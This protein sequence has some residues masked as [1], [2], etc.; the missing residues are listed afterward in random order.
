MKLL[1]ASQMQDVDSRAIDERGIPGL[2]LMEQAGLRCVDEIDDMFAGHRGRALI[3]VGK[4]NNGGDGLVIARHLRKG[5]WKVAVFCASNPDE[6]SGDAAI[7]LRRIDRSS[8]LLF[9]DMDLLPS[10]INDSDLIVDALLGTGL[11]STLKGRYLDII[12][13]VNDS[14][15]VVLAVDLPSGV[16]ATTGEVMGVAILADV[17]VTFA[18]PKLGHVLYPGA[19]H[20]GRLVVVDIGIPP[21]LL[22][23]EGAVEYIDLEAASRLIRRRSP[24]AHK[25]SCGHCLVVAGST[26]KTGAAAMAANSAVRSGAGLVTAAIPESLNLIMEIKTDEAMTLP[27]PDGCRGAFSPESM[28]EL[29]KALNG[30]SVLALGPGISLTDGVSDVVASLLR[31]IAIPAVVDADGLNAIA[32]DV[33]V[34]QERQASTPLVLTPHPGELSRLCR[35]SVAEIE[36]DR[37]GMARKT[38]F[39]YGV[40]LVL[41]GA[42]TVVASP[43]GAIAINGSGNAGMASG[44]MGD[45]LTGVIAALLAQGYEPES[46]CRL[47]VFAHGLAADIA[48]GEIGEIGLCATEVMKQLPLA[49]NRILQRKESISC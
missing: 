46:A 49:F 14:D 9:T 4:G 11:T 43:D 35:C 29:V 40:W 3:L 18:A 19:T 2:E 44:G 12:T 28:P 10:L 27:I 42:R 8:V 1:T 6:F 5:G 30:K 47:G 33:S 45:V 21:D 25:G 17:T 23:H 31:Q 20:A 32:E 34:L 7:N 26:G 38:A 15:K 36:S 24:T 41:K 22:E 16:N 13:A 37:I 39:D 48:A